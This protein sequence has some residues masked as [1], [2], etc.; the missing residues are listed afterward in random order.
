MIDQSKF[1]QITIEGQKLFPSDGNVIESPTKHYLVPVESIIQVVADRRDFLCETPIR[2]GN[3]GS[4]GLHV[5]FYKTVG[6]YEVEDAL[7]P[8]FREQEF[9]NKGL[10]I[11]EKEL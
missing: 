9:I 8:L 2:I 6:S 4:K 5:K 11:I 3:S 1:I 7:L 10:S